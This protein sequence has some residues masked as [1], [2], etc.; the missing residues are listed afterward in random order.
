MNWT[1]LLT[2]QQV[3]EIRTKSCHAPQVI[4]KHS[5]RC[6]TSSIAKNRLEKNESLPTVFYLVDVIR[7][8][9]LSNK[10]AS[11][12]GI[13]HESPQILIIKNGTCIYHES[14]YGINADA[15]RIH[16]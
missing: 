2:E 16:L 4:F 15:V 10:I 13:H 9:N 1:P 3:E 12:F 8:R 6:G 5:T 11:D 7:N 14:H